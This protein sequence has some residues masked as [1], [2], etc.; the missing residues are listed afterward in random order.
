MGGCSGTPVWFKTSE[1]SSKETRAKCQWIILNEAL[2]VRAAWR[3]EADRNAPQT[4]MNAM[5]WL[6]KHYKEDFFLYVD[7][8]DPH[9]P[10]GAPAHYI[11]LYL[12]DY[13][14]QLVLPDYGNWHDVPGYE[15]ELMQK[16]HATYLCAGLFRHKAF[17][18]IVE[19]R[20]GPPDQV[21]GDD[22]AL[23]TWMKQAVIT[24][25]HVSSTCK[26][27]PPSESPAVVD[28]YCR[29]HGLDGLRVVD[30]SI[31]PDTVRANLNLTVIAMAERAADII[32][33][34]SGAGRAG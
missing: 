4:F 34:S 6:E 23:D 30:A 25:H 31:M 1:V 27:G 21:L 22:A 18:G 5:R 10:W 15:E 24:A 17:D 28:Q 16:G 8:W 29:V 26:M 13:D 19:Q 20:V 33:G 3:H 7:T 12:P 9:E 14:G 2:D 11:E 32:K